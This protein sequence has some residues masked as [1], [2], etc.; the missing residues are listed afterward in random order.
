MT[1]FEDLSG[2]LTIGALVK[3]H[4]TSYD[5]SQEQ[6]AKKLKTTKSF[7]QQI[8]NGK[9]KLSLKETLKLAQKLGEFTDF[10]ALVW[11]ETEARDAG[12]DFNQFIN[13]NRD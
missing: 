4:R 3:A 10:F 1:I 9:K 13:Q 11:F 5:L 2:P 12:F 6:L 8:E 7:V